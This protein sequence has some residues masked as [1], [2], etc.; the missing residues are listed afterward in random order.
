[1]RSHTT[2]RRG[3]NTVLLTTLVLA[4]GFAHAHDEDWRKIADRTNTFVGPIVRAA[5][6]AANPISA[7]TA[8]NTF[9]SSNI[10]LLSWTP[11]NNFPGSGNV[12]ANDCWGYVSPSGR[13][14]ALIGLRCDFGFVEITD[15][16]NP[17]ILTPTIRP[18]ATSPCSLWSDI[19][20]VGEY[21]YGVSEGGGGIQIYDLRDIDNGNVIFVKN[22]ELGGHTTTH[23]IVANPETETIYAVGAN[24]AN[25]G[26][27]A[28]DV[29]D[30]ENPTLAGAWSQRYVHDAQV[31]SYD[32][33]PLAGRE[34]AY[35][36]NGGFG[37]EVIDV[38]NRNAMAR[39]GGS[40]YGTIA[41]CHQGWLSEDKQ[42]LFVNDELDEQTF[43]L[44]TT[45]SRIFD[46][47]DPTNPTFVDTYTSGIT[48]IDHNNYVAGDLIF[49]ANYRSGLRVFD[50]TVPASPAEVAFFDTHPEGDGNN[51]NGAW[52]AYPYLPSKNVIV[53]DIERGLFVL[54]VVPFVDGVL[55]VESSLASTVEPQIPTAVN[56]TVETRLGATLDPASVEL[57]Y[58]VDG[59]TEA[60]VAM[61]PDGNGGFAGSIPAQPCFTNVDFRVVASSTTGAPFESS[62]G[63]FTVTTGAEELFTDSFQ[64]NLGWAA[65]EVSLTDG[66]WDRGTPAGAGDRGDPIADFDGSGQCWL[67]DNVAGNSD[68]DGGPARLTSPTIDLANAE[69]ATLRFAYWHYSNGG[70]PLTVELS[71][72]NGSSWTTAATFTGVEGVVWQTAEIEVSDFVSLTSQ[73]RVRFASND[74]PN[75]SVTESAIDAVVIETATCEVTNLA[76]SPADVTTTGNAEGIPDGAVDLSDF[77]F[78]LS[79]WS[80]SDDRADVTT[81]GNANGVPDGSVDLSDFSFYLSL[82]SAG[83][84]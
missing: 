20:V 78:Y 4:A 32:S 22:V 26:L 53:S 63:S 70:D 36:F 35:C 8:R 56:A 74:N 55:T 79:L 49:Q 46:V 34:I 10:E 59:G 21:A 13:E 15:P 30:R 5:G 37:V 3:P 57:R 44:S 69:R 76:C 6:D 84:P 24:I 82:W 75:N 66:G 65:S 43:G 67:T 72:N 19:K 62:A 12:D 54:R 83:C 68:V 81:T 31:V 1:M 61:L 51:F 11:V 14:Y 27:V 39:I 40:T 41:Y 29:S 48:S 18:G 25:G 2:S 60:T 71:S 9:E 7:A 16:T 38:T 42:T 28:F 17:V 64:T 50:A 52:S 45:R 58:T 23:N 80:A 47:S 33:G 77:S 73:F